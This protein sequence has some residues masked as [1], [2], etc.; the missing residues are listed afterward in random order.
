MLKVTPLG[1]TRPR[2]NALP[3]YTVVGIELAEKANLDQGRY[4]VIRN[5]VVSCIGSLTLH[6]M[7]IEL[8]VNFESIL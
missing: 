5:L 6:C 4:I 1:Y 3:W 8:L 7:L 2:A